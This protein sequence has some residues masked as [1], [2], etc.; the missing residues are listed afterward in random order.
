VGVRL[1][2]RNGILYALISAAL[3]G[4]SAPLAKILLGQTSPWLLAGLLYL[5]SGLGLAIARP[6]LPR[7]EAKLQRADIPWLGGAILAGGIIGPVL[8]MFGLAQGA[9][10]AT[11]LLLNLESVLTLIL[12]W[13]VFRENVDSRLLVGAAAIVAGAI[14]LSWPNANATG[15]SLNSALLVAGACLAWAIDN[16]LTRKVSAADPVVTAM[17]KGLIAGAVNTAIAFGTGAHL[18]AFGTIAAAA[19]LGFFGYG[20]SLTL[21]VLALRHLGTARTGA[22]Y[23]SAPFIGAAAAIL[24]LSEPVTLPFIAGGLLMAIGLYLHLTERHVHAHAHEELD[25]DHQHTHDEHHQHTHGPGT[26]SEPHAHTHHHTR[27]I[28]KH[29]HYPDLHHRHTH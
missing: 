5:G 12:A 9:A 6:F 18:P 2:H 25:H 21:F 28:H 11:S 15:T 3:F 23:A 1:M 24:L 7:D 29:R 20:I 4:V 22:Y 13:V 26:P 14:V 8:L 16:N 17:L 27:L 19:L 10:G